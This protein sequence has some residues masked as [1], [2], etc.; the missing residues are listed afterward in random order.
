MRASTLQS[1]I[2]FSAGLLESLYRDP[3][4]VLLF[5]RGRE[6]PQSLN[7]A[8]RARFFYFMLGFVRIAQNVHHQFEQGLMNQD[9]W[10]GYRESILQMLERPGSR[11]WWAENATRFSISFRTFLDN[12]LERRA[13]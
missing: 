8:E 6:D 5:D 7:E 13:A 3:E 11:Q 4:L 9:I 1:A 2:Q 10:N 12:E